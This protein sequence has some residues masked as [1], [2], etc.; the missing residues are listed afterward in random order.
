MKLTNRLQ[1]IADL[2]DKEAKVADI[3]TDHGYL[4]VYLIEKKMIDKAIAADINKLPLENAKAIIK[5]YKYEDK[6]ETR[7]GSGL[8]VLKIGEIDTAII[9]GMGGVLITELLN[10][11]L[12]LTKSIDTFVL[13]PMVDSDELRK[14][15]IENNFV[16]VDET[17]AI[18]DKRYYEIIVAKT[19]GKMSLEKHDDKLGPILKTKDLKAIKQFYNYHIDKNKKIIDKIKKN[20]KKDAN[21][22]INELEDLIKIMEKVILTNENKGFYKNN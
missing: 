8:E 5:E 10:E 21:I 6:I 13:Q 20:S 9:A 3:G 22:R 18:E 7:L 12:E 15:L 16:I 2:I 17:I 19:N 11:N 1:K 14:Y 4:P